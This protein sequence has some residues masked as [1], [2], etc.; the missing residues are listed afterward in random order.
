MEEGKRGDLKHSRTKGLV[1]FCIPL[2]IHGD[3][4]EMQNNDSLM[5]ISFTSLLAIGS[6]RELNCLIAGWPYST[7]VKQKHD[8]VDTWLEIW[9]VI[10]WSLNSLA[11]GKFPTRDAK[12]SP[13]RALEGALNL[14]PH[15]PEQHETC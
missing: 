11:S 7:H 8:G 12:A 6:T 14:A 5:C 10:V 4:A 1:G 15:L 3:G 2:R 9:R 13:F